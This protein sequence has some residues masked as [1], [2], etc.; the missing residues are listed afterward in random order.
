MKVFTHRDFCQ[1]YVSDP[2][3]APGRIE[4]ILDAIGDEVILEEAVPAGWD[5][6]EAVHTAR[7]IDNVTQRGLYPIAALAAGA[8]IRLRA[9]ASRSLPS[10]WFDLRGITLLRT[11]HGASV[12]STTWPLPWTT[13]AGP[14]GSPK[15]TC[16]TSICISETAR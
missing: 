5:D 13:C 12:I 10:H 14:K 1:V 2:A 6:I 16:W 3:A 11:A 4:A 7:H 9:S 8:T 15:R